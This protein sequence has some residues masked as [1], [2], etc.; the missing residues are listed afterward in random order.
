M[1]P[2]RVLHLI[3]SPRLTARADARRVDS[4]RRVL[5]PTYS[6]LLACRDHV[7]AAR[8][9]EPDTQHR[10]VLVA[11]PDSAD[12]VR[13]SGLAPDRILHPP[14]A[15]PALAWSRCRGERAWNP[16]AVR[17]WSPGLGTLARLCK[18]SGTIE[19]TPWSLGDAPPG[20]EPT[21]PAFRA[22]A[23]ERHIA[24]RA[25]QRAALALQDRDI[26]LVLLA[27]PPAAADARDFAYL[28]GMLEIAVGPLTALI[29]AAARAVRR[30]QRFDRLAIKRSTLHFIESST[31]DWL[32][33]ADAAVLRGPR[34]A[35]SIA[36]AHAALARGLP[37]VA[38]VWV[39]PTAADPTRSDADAPRLF[40]SDGRARTMLPA[41]L[42]ALHAAA[43][44]LPV[45]A[46]RSAPIRPTERAPESSLP[47]RP[48]PRAQ[49]STA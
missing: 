30:A 4:P 44:W 9:T 27:D 22:P 10:V 3:R 23:N 16:T 28:L 6:A 42:R 7:D 48:R 8:T 15:I 11:A 47:H 38:P 49:Q 41:S 45:E 17:L 13:S 12:A 25:A 33:A 39:A 5:E 19:Q 14:L 34:S 40:I 35:A 46:A 37:L 26:L 20:D 43:P 18:A 21:T 29:P 31:L 2:S 1:P 32:D 24:R 36:A